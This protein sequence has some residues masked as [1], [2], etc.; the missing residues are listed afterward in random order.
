MPAANVNVTNIGFVVGNID[1]QTA[2]RILKVI[3]LLEII[4]SIGKEILN[5]SGRQH[6][7]RNRFNIIHESLDI[8]ID[9]AQQIRGGIGHLILDHFA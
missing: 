2:G 4:L 8:P 6:Q 7:L 3:D 5:I 1:D 9:G